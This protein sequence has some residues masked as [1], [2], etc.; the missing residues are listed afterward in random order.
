MSIIAMLL[1][2][3]FMLGGIAGWLLRGKDEDFD[4]RNELR[5]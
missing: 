5:K 4:D 3:A 1:L 2:A